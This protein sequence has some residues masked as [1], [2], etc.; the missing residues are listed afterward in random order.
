MVLPIRG[1]KIGREAETVR[2]SEFRKRDLSLADCRKGSGDTK[3]Q[4][5]GRKSK[6]KYLQ[7]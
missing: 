6:K 2:A 4:N 7:R 5:G 1:K 3:N